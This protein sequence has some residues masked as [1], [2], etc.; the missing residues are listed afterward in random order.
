MGASIYVPIYPTVSSHDNDTSFPTDN[1]IIEQE[2]IG[3]YHNNHSY[4]DTMDNI[5]IDW[6]TFTGL[7]GSTYV[8][9]GSKSSLPVA[10]HC[11]TLPQEL[12]LPKITDMQIHPKALELMIYIN[13]NLLSPSHIDSLWNGLEVAPSVDRTGLPM[14]ELESFEKQSDLSFLP[15]LHGRELKCINTYLMNEYWMGQEIDNTMTYSTSHPYVKLNEL[16][17]NV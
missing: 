17:W 15:S 12:K 3:S 16:Q 10:S 7:N 14:S 6:S 1:D 13:D 4:T 5:E 8:Y 2:S 11:L 9:K